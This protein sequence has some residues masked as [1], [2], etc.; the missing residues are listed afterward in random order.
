MEQKRQELA[1]AEIERE[2][3]G[4]E[5]RISELEQQGQKDEEEALRR[6]LDSLRVENAAAPAA[7]RKPGA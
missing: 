5:L 7:G 3:A 1:A 6:R 2:I 4:L